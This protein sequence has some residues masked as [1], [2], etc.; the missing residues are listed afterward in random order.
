M[1]K[2]PFPLVTPLRWR[3]RDSEITGGCRGQWLAADDVRGNGSRGRVP[4]ARKTA[5]ATA[6]GRAGLCGVLESDEA[7]VS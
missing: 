2:V 1:K 7:S 3:T 5:T 6:E 4:I